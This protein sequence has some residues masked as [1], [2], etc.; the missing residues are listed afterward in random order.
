MGAETMFLTVGICTW[1]RAALLDQALTSLAQARVPSGIRW[2]VLVVNNHCTDDTD[3]VIRTHES[4]LPLTRLYE[5]QPGLSMARNRLLQ[6][7]EGD[8]LLWTDDDVRVDADWLEAAVD[9][10]R[11]HPTA[12]GFAGRIRPWFPR[13]PDPL[14]LQA[15][16]VLASGFCGLDLGP[17]PRVMTENEFAYGANM[18]FQT[19]LVQGLTF[20]PKLGPMAQRATVGDDVNY[21]MQIRARGGTLIWWPA[22]A[23]DHYVA[24]ERMTLPYLTRYY[25]AAG[26]SDTRL[27]GIPAGPRWFGVP[28]YLI[29][30]AAA[31]YASFLIH[32]VRGRRG[33]ALEQLRTYHYYRGV[34]AACRQ[35]ATEPRYA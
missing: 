16:P 35:L 13:Q 27:K 9:A 1:N 15:F 18:M 22:L 33:S 28:R 26:M 7:A 12:A 29:R 3:A 2:Q 5:A 6:H 4:H 32:R 17:L 30:L 10:A 14:L 21:Q 23:V 34:I 11:Q 20:D 25:Q 8:W 19:R 24:P 31:K